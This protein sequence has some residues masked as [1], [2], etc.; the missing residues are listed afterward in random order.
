MTSLHPVVLHPVVNALGW[1]RLRP[2]QEQAVEPILAGHD[3]LLLAPTAG[4]KTEAAVIPLLSAMAAQGWRGLSV[5]YVCPLRALLNNLEPRLASYAGWL[6]LRAALWHGDTSDSRLQRALRDQREDHPFDRVAVQA[7][8]GRDPADRRA[9]P[10]SFPNP[11]RRPRSAQRPG[12]DD[13][14]CPVRGS[15][16]PPWHGTNGWR[17]R[18]VASGAGKRPLQRHEQVDDGWR[19]EDAVPLFADVA[20]REDTGSHEPVDCGT[21]CD[22]GPADE[23]GSRLDGHQR[24]AWQYLGE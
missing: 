24:Y 22:H 18:R 8:A 17:N 14:P 12:V 4:G 5:L 2:L 20:L 21:R 19:F 15:V 23:P 9:D 7:P 13:G 11:V 3:V 16:G 6:G 10:Q 1:P